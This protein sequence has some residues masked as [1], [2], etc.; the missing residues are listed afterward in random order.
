MAKQIGF[1]NTTLIDIELKQLGETVPV[2]QGSPENILDLSYLPAVSFRKIPSLE[3]LIVSGDIIIFDGINDLPSSEGYHYL[4]DDV[5]GDD[6]GFWHVNRRRFAIK[7][8]KPAHGFLS[9]DVLYID[10]SGVPQKAIATS[11]LTSSAANIVMEVIDVDNYYACS[12]SSTVTPDPTVIEGGLP[13]NIGSSYFLS[14]T[15][16]GKM[17]TIPPSGIGE[18]V[19]LVG[20]AI[21][22]YTLVILN[23][24]S[25]I[26]DTTLIASE[27]TAL[28]AGSSVIT[29]TGDWH[30]AI[31]DIVDDPATLTP[32]TGDR[33]IVGTGIN[34]WT[35][36][37]GDI[38]E[39]NAISSLW[40]S[41]TPN[42]STITYN[43]TTEKII[44]FD[45]T[46][47]SDI[48][49]GST[50]GPPAICHRNNGSIT[51][52]F[53]S[54]YSTI[55]IGT[56]VKTDASTYTV[57]NDEVT[58]LKS[59]WYRIEYDISADAT[60]DSRSSMEHILE[61][62]GTLIEGSRAY[63]YHKKHDVGSATAHAMAWVNLTANNVIR[64]RSKELNGNTVTKPNACRLT[65]EYY[66]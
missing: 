5:V 40:V 64:M 1:K 34:I 57:L 60:S 65:L 12:F 4:I 46:S 66:G 36:K 59:G 39:Y 48:L 8:N 21:D 49:S 31:I 50:V 53:T 35:G 20:L 44:K 58:V 52:T 30:K 7:T 51:Q 17:T 3:A 47:W 23:H 2:N 54:S 63:S 11:H 22:A 29:P 10:V 13:L 61:K 14:A 55:L 38:V 24:P 25:Y 42:I 45:G 41:L 33:Y 9:G 27:I 37:D 43:K 18:T 56:D 15:Q 16:A 26:N 28:Q 32:S 6:D 19:K 62:D